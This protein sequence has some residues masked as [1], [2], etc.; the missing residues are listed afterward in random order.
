MGLPHEKSAKIIKKNKA[1][2]ILFLFT[3]AF[4]I[5]LNPYNAA[6]ATAIYFGLERMYEHF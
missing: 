2:M 1:T 3:F 6:A 4:S 5:N